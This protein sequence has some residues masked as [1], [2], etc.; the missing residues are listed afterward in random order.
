MWAGGKGRMLKH[1]HSLIP[2]TID[3]YIEP[4][5]GGGAMFLYVVKNR[6]PSKLI[7][8]DINPDIVNIYQAIRDDL[9]EFSA[10]I[11]ALEAKYIPM[12]KEDR[13][14]Y[15]FEVRHEHAY[16]YVQW[17]KPREAATLYFLMKTG[18]NGI[19]QI[20]KNTNGRFGT[21]SGLLNQVDV[22]YD[23]EVV[24][25]WHEV[26]QRAEIKAG[27]WSDAIPPSL[28]DDTFVFLDPPYRGSFTTYGQEFGDD[29]QSEVLDFAKKT[30]AN[31]F[32]CNR[33]VEGDPFFKDGILGTDLQI[34]Y[35]DITYTAGRRKKVDD[36][37]EAKKAIEI[38]VY[39]VND[40]LR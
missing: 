29:R 21:P 18:F 27:N 22:V 40:F 16:D 4:F 39:R 20:N 37:F 14:K 28:T 35:F 30:S 10:N 23:R 36:G 7:I 13:K 5:F 33:D 17:S 24:R 19:F 38:L 15:Y 26:L 31:V 25:Y 2:S 9:S 1:Y 12:S 32:L 34:A 3:T 6:N 8:N 11:D